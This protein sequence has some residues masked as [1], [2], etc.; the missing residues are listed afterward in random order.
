[1]ELAFGTRLLLIIMSVIILGTAY[2]TE[3]TPSPFEIRFYEDYMVVYPKNIIM[4]G[5]FHEKNMI[6]FFIKILSVSNIKKYRK[7]Q[8]L[9]LG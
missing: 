8:Y 9:W 5:I 1:M 3:K 7:I 4:T 6:S 2:A